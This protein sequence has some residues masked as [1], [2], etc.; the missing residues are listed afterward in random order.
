MSREPESRGP[1]CC[2]AM[3]SHIE[4][5]EVAIVYEE[6]FRQYGIDFRTGGIQ[7]IAFC[8]WCGIKLP[9]DL[10]DEWFGVLDGELRLRPDDPA[11][12]QEMQ[13][14]IWWRRRGL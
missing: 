11:M 3:A 10:V 7:L 4:G 12:P 1:H 9:K 2:G 13:T 6:R 14:A 5:G 8:P